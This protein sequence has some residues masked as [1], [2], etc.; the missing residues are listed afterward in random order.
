MTVFNSV[1]GG[2]LA[3]HPNGHRGLR[4]VKPLTSMGNISP[5]L[6]KFETFTNIFQLMTTIF[7]AISNATEYTQSN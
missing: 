4:S 5:K 6:E 3:V 1:V 7:N 2:E